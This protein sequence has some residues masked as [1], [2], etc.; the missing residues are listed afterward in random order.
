M[1]EINISFNIFGMEDSGSGLNLVN[2]DYRQSVVE[3]P[4]NLVLKFTYSKDLYN[5]DLSSVSLL[6][7][8][9]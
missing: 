2:L 1:G 7:G 3:Q 4:S 5:V 9:K 8:G 6:Y